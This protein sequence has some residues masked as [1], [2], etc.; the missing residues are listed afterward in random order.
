V[1]KSKEKAVNDTEE[2]VADYLEIRR[3]RE[4]LKADYESQD[5]ELKDAMES[6]KEAL[7]AICN[8]NNQN[9]FKTNS[10]TVTRQV[11]D[12]FFCTDWDNFKKFIESQGSI[13]LLE[14]RIHQRNFKE[15]MSERA[16]D[17]LPPGVNALREYDIVV[18]KASS[19]SETLV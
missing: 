11:K 7:L 14:R 1:K 3:M 16:G 15:F 17:G 18:R 10:G 6:I 12:R 19:T 9:G 2:L 4:S 5:E 8:E 13:D